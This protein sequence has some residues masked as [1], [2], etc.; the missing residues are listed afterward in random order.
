M[1]TNNLSFSSCLQVGVYIPNA[2]PNYKEMVNQFNFFSGDIR[3]AEIT[4][5]ALH[6]LSCERKQYPEQAQQGEAHDP[7]NAV[8][9]ACRSA[10]GKSV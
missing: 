2:P 7:H 4:S 6:R 9:E 3:Q 8:F 10:G 1:P 5:T